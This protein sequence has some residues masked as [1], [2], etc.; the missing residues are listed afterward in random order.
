MLAIDSGVNSGPRV[1]R[2]N[3]GMG[4]DEDGEWERVAAVSDPVM[5]AWRSGVL[6]ATDG[7]SGERIISMWR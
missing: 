4:S 6:G 3:S 5:V 2:A 7:W 1:S